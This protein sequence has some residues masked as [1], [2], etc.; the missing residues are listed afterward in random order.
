MEIERELKRYDS[1]IS[2]SGNRVSFRVSLEWAKGMPKDAG[3]YVFYYRNKIVYVGQSRSLKER[4]KDL[5]RTVNHT[6]RRKLG[7]FYFAKK[8]GFQKATSKKKFP[9]HIEKM[10]NSRMESMKIVI[11]PVPFGRS[12]VEEYLIKKYKPKFNANTS[13]G[14]T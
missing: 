2:K 4:M 6:F 10:V 12:E 14:N 11:V 1:Y 7:N 5:R 9:E 8:D 13:R 3:I